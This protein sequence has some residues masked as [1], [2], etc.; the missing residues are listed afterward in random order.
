MF[1]PVCSVT[2]YGSFTFDNSQMCMSDL[3]NAIFTEVCQN[4]ENL[5]LIFKNIDNI[6]L[7]ESKYL[8]IKYEISHEFVLRRTST[9]CIVNNIDKDRVALRFVNQYAIQIT[10]EL[11]PAVG[12]V[13]DNIQMDMC[14]KM[15]SIVKSTFI[16]TTLGHIHSNELVFCGDTSFCLII[17]VL[18]P[19]A[20]NIEILLNPSIFKPQLNQNIILNKK[21]SLTLIRIKRLS[22]NSECVKMYY[23]LVIIAKKIRQL[24]GLFFCNFLGMIFA[25][26]FIGTSRTHYDSKYELRI[27]LEVYR[28]N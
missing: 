25:H 20:N 13:L 16:L 1:D 24:C 4:R 28:C 6:F 11:Y 15:L 5:Q 23:L 8:K 12:P 14:N 7:A 27:T 9:V 3:F 18:L 26:R 21:Q 22:S 17:E 2:M 10:D 19:C